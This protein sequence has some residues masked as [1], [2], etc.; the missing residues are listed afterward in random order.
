MEAR[1]RGHAAMLAYS[2]MVAG[3]FSLGSLVA[4][5]LAPAVLNAVRF[6]IAGAVLGAATWAAGGLSRRALAAPWRH[7][8]LGALMAAYFYLMFEGL[9]TAPAVSSAAVFTLTPAMAGLFGWLLLRQVITPRMALALALGAVGALWVIFR[10]DL[11]AALALDV[12]RGEAV[13]FWGCAAHA[14]YTPL[15]RRLNRGE[16]ALGFTFGVTL[17]TFG[18]LALVALPDLPRTDWAGLPARVWLTILYLAV[19]ASALS[20]VCVQYATLRLPSAKVMAYT[21]LVPSWVIVWELARG[22]SPPPGLVLV[23]IGLSVLALLLLLKDEGEG[24][25][26]G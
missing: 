20:F 24:G 9:K 16:S 18:C 17:A 3:S 5:D 14:L 15:V 12:G 7:A 23:G 11:S 8:V 1:L 21:Y 22:R 26:S 25:R 6:L 10:A 13:F 4:N 19:F 2:V